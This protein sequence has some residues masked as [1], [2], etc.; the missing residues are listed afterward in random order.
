VQDEAAAAA[1][2]AATA[3]RQLLQ[4]GAAQHRTTAFQGSTG[5][6]QLLA[7][8]ATVLTSACVRICRHIM[9]L[10]G[11]AGSPDTPTA[12]SPVQPP[13]PTHSSKQSQRTQHAT[14]MQQRAMALRAG[15]YA[16]PRAAV[17]PA[18]GAGPPSAKQPA[19]PGDEEA[20]LLKM[21]MER[22]K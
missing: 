12:V 17:T 15:G 19:A 3:H 9:D 16:H 20:R 13:A 18:G 22:T 11:T 1:A 6:K 4:S 2:F 8:D 5:H 14:K 21:L 10:T 7:M